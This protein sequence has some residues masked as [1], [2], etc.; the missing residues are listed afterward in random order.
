M[1]TS[2]A[3]IKPQRAHRAKKGEKLNA[4]ALLRT[5][6]SIKKV[7]KKHKVTAQTI[8]RWSKNY[9]NDEI[10]NTLEIQNSNE[11][12]DYI[13]ACVTNPECIHAIELG[14]DAY[15]QVLHL[16]KI[17]ERSI[18]GQIRYLIKQAYAAQCNRIPF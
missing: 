10:N 13:N 18:D 11:V 16:C 3:N 1:K 2:Y 17:E 5:G 14:P 9:G 7:A 15:E 4:V 8:Y 12:D 6:I